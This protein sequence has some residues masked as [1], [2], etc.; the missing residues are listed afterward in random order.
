MA[1][2]DWKDCSHQDYYGDN[3][4]GFLVDVFVYDPGQKEG[5][6]RFL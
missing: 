5:F 4:G 2:C 1:F 3:L 6:K